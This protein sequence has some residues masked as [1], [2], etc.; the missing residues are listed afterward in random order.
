MAK[1][2]ETEAAVNDMLGTIATCWWKEI[3]VCLSN[4]HV[5]DPGVVDVEY[6]SLCSSTGTC[7]CPNLNCK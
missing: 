1:N 7:F 5:R 6:M 2:Q 3:S 4:V